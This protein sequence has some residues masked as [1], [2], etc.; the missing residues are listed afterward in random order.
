MVREAHV[1]DV[2]GLAQRIGFGE[3]PELLSF[4]LGRRRVLE[5]SLSEEERAG[6]AGGAVQI[7]GLEEVN[8]TF[9]KM[10][11]GRGPTATVIVQSGTLKVGQ[12]FICGPCSGKVKSLINDRGEPVKGAGPA[13]P[14]EVLGF[15][16]L[17]NVGDE[18]V[19]MDSERSAKRLSEERQEEMRQRKLAKPNAPLPKK[20]WPR[21]RRRRKK[22][23]RRY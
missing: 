15:N 20:L 1:Q 5:C 11:A 22:K 19:E 16:A 23:L 3:Y 2:E 10:E 6:D 18:L 7:R 14:V 17:P 12:P 8:G 4:D 9:A 13:V 21:P